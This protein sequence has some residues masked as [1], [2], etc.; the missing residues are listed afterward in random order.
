MSEVAVTSSI[1]RPRDAVWSVL[2][3]FDAISRWAPNVDHSSLT[4][5]QTEGA[6]AERRVQVG[7]NAL[8]ERVV[9]WE[10]GRR[11]GYEITGLPPVVRSARNTWTLDDSGGATTVTLTTQV[12]AGPRP[13]QQLIARAIGRAM[14]RA[15]RE[16]LAGLKTQL[17]EKR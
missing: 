17:E 4:T 1:D 7:R 13:P 3:E 9:E 15:S 12:E 11:L 5:A 14:A 16:L 2:A 10:P 6:G 8:L